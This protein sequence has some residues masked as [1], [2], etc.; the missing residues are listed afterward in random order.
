M[1]F[2]LLVAFMF[3]LGV[4]GKRGG[5]DSY[6]AIAIAAGIASFWALH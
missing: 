1:P 4:I 6:A 3:L 2:F 5:R